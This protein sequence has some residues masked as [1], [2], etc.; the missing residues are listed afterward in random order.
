MWSWGHGWTWRASHWWSRRRSGWRRPSWRRSI[1]RHARLQRHRCLSWQVRHQRSSSGV[2]RWHRQRWTQLPWT[3][4]N[5]SNATSR[6]IHREGVSVQLALRIA[7]IFSISEDDRADL[8]CASGANLDTLQ[9]TPP[10]KGFPDV[11]FGQL[12]SEGKLV[13]SHRQSGRA[14]RGW[15]CW[16][17]SRRP[18]RRCTRS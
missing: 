1:W 9:R 2:R 3:A 17:P 18:W 15:R 6:A 16:R 5:Y 12:I 11:S 14:C 10:L 7:G 13:N 4:E 8:T